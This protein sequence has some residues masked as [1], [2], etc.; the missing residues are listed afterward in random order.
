MRCTGLDQPHPSPARGNFFGI[1]CL[2]YS[3]AHL[4]LL[5]KKKNLLGLLLNRCKRFSQTN[6]GLAAKARM[7]Q[8]PWRRR[9]G[10]AARYY[11]ARFV[12]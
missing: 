3:L 10:E 7:I 1:I 5:P 8:L 4:F 11:R 2:V 12:P 6:R 9:L